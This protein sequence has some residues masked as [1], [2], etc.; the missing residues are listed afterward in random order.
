MSKN[1]DKTDQAIGI[2]IGLAG[3]SILGYFA[4]LVLDKYV[5]S[6]VDWGALFST[7]LWYAMIIGGVV[8]LGIAVFYSLRYFL[9]D[10]PK[11]QRKQRKAKAKKQKAKGEKILAKLRKQEDS[12]QRKTERTANTIEDLQAELPGIDR[13]IGKHHKMQEKLRASGHKP[14]AIG[15]ALSEIQQVIEGL[16]SKKEGLLQEIAELQQSLGKSV[17]TERELNEEA[18]L[19]DPDNVKLLV[20]RCYFYMNEDGDFD[21]AIADAERA[22][23]IIPKDHDALLAYGTVL[24]SLGSK[25]LATMHLE[26]MIKT[27]PRS[28][29]ARTV[30]AR[31]HIDRQRY[32]DALKVAQPALD[33]CSRTD[34]LYVRVELA[35]AYN[36]LGKHEEAVKHLSIIVDENPSFK[37]V[38]FH[39]AELLKKLGKYDL[40]ERDL[41]RY[42]EL[43]GKLKEA[44]PAPSAPKPAKKADREKQSGQQTAQNASSAETQS[45]ERKAQADQQ[46]AGN[47]HEREEQDREEHERVMGHLEDIESGVVAPP[48][49]AFG[50]LYKS[51]DDG[52]DALKTCVLFRAV[53]MFGNAGDLENTYKFAKMMLPHVQKLKNVCVPG[54]DEVFSSAPAVATYFVLFQCCMKQEDILQAAKYIHECMENCD[55]GDDVLPRVM[56]YFTE[57]RKQYPDGRIR[58]WL[59]DFYLYFDDRT[60]SDQVFGLVNSYL[61]EFY[62]TGNDAYFDLAE[63][64]QFAETAWRLCSSLVAKGVKAGTWWAICEALE[65]GSGQ[66]KVGQHYTDPK[67]YE[68]VETIG[69]EA[70]ERLNLTPA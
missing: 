21:K 65:Q 68:V 56:G 13:E 37:D 15:A 67:V 26:K 29:M 51:I 69:R 47:K 8:V 22:L 44:E 20:D 24:H 70:M 38:L 63:A 46:Q 48:H 32:S 66:R 64:E 16:Q 1:D 17:R 25:V 2:V 42:R 58:D 49:L 19:R 55:D 34:H 61:A 5:I 43:G 40:A 36:G 9:M 7:V 10:R 41:A 3:L 30:L 23:E 50:G 60:V 57:L 4:Y 33:F 14:E 27:H 35:R 62:A 59:A 11:S 45:G 54:S 28:V 39:R 31:T 52:N 53:Q 12:T 18:L 6:P